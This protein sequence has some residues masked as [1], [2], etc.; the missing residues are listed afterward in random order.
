MSRVRQ[1]K[2]VPRRECAQDAILVV[3]EALPRMRARIGIGRAVI[4]QEQHR[5]RLVLEPE[6]RH[7]G[8]R[9]GE[10]LLGE[11]YFEP[12]GQLA[13]QRA[14]Y[15]RWTQTYDELGIASARRY[16]D[17]RGRKVEPRDQCSD[18]SDRANTALTQALQP[19]L[20]CSAAG[21]QP[22]LV[23][24][25]A[26]YD[27]QGMLT[28]SAYIGNAVDPVSDCVDAKLQKLALE[29]APDACRSLHAVVDVVLNVVL[30]G[31]E[32]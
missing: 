31:R 25:S 30:I 2:P 16:F 13:D 10:R 22:L 20:S 24:F 11:R 28:S 1:G 4:G 5:Q 9:D 21:G 14:G 8:D 27:A 23:F 15:A 3:D 32:P 12:H 17:A 7:D 19:L 18:I 29:P 6:H 26:Q